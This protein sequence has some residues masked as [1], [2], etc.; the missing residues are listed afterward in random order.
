M[1]KNGKQ[2][3]YLVHLIEKSISPND[4]V[5]HNVQ[6]PI[7]TSRIGATTQC[8]IVI[9]TGTPPRQTITLVEVQDRGS[10]VKINDFRGWKEKLK[11]V[12]AQHLICVS[13]HEFSKTIKEQASLSGSSIMLVTLKEATPEML[14][15]DFMRFYYQFRNFDLIAITH[16][17]PTICNAKEIPL[18][19]KESIHSKC[20]VESNEQCWSVDGQ[21]L[22]SLF[23]LCRDCYLPPDGVVSGSGSI[24][25]DCTEGNPLYYFVNGV[26]IRVGL[27]CKFDWKH[28][29]I[30]KPV[31]ILT[32]EQNEHG[33]L[34]WVAEVSHDSSKG[35]IAVRVPII[36]MGDHYIAYPPQ[37]ELPEDSN[38]NFDI[39]S[40]DR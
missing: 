29:T 21:N 33:T 31:S 2:L 3:E 18:E 34:A 38:F 37:T 13:K 16:M 9:R 19:I 25:F 11:N 40:I 4:E 32:Y 6:M 20:S 22:I 23:I 17:Q 24:K 1:A 15:L 12:G 30:Q 35:R 10:K 26:F 28:E 7:L 8:D 39:C 5:E 14:P 36:Q 27:D